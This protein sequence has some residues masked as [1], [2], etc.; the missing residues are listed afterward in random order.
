MLVLFFAFNLDESVST[1]FVGFLIEKFKLLKVLDFSNAPIDYIPEAVG[2][3]YLLKSL[4]IRNTKVRMLRKSIGKLHNLRTLDLV[5]TPIHKL[6]IV[7]NKLQNLQHLSGFY[8]DHATGY[9]NGALHGMRLK[10]GIRRLV[11][12][13]TLTNVE[14]YHQHHQGFSLVKELETLSQLRWLGISLVN[15][16][17]AK[18]SL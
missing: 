12:L 7:V 1:S 18:I 13:Q 10:E 11:E 8:H 5:N 6:S 16:R 4:N 2:K 3:L 17:N 14:A 15:Y 9:D